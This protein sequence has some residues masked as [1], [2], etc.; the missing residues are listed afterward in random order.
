MATITTAAE[1]RALDGDRLEELLREAKEELFNL[2]FQNATGQLDNTARLRAVRKDIARV[3]TVMRE[4]ELGIVE[5]PS[6]EALSDSGA[7]A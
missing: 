5:A 6:D 2:R 1:L 4:R 7:N 3:Y